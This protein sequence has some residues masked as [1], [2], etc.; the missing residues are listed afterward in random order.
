[1]YLSE[2][3]VLAAYKG[4]KQ[5][6]L[7]E[8]K[9]RQE[10]VSALRHLLASCELM[11]QNNTDTVSL[12]V[13][14]SKARSDFI[15]A[16]SR[17]VS[18]SSEGDYTNDFHL[19]FA[20]R[21]DFGVRSNFFTTRL[22]D[23]R[24]HSLEYPGR[25]K[26]LLHLDNEVVSLTSEINSNLESAYS[27]KKIRAYLALWLLRYTKLGL[28]SENIS[29]KELATEIESRLKEIYHDSI[30]DIF[31][32]T[33]SE[34]N[35]ILVNSAVHLSNEIVNLEIILALKE[36]T[37]EEDKIVEKAHVLKN[38]LGDS[39]EIYVSITK[40]LERGSKGILLSGPPGTSKT[41]Y[42]LKLALKLTEGDL[43]RISR[44][45][46][47]QS[48]SYEDFIEGL[49][50]TGSV[51]GTEPLFKPKFKTFVNFCLKAKN[52]IDNNYYLI[53]DEFTRGDPSRIFGELLTYIEPDYRDIEFILPYSEEKFSVPQNVVILA[54]MNPYDKSVID[55]DAAMERRFEIIELAPSREILTQFLTTNAVSGPTIGNIVNFF[56][57]LNKFAEHGF[58]HTYFK[59]IRTEEDLIM[60]WNHKLKFILEK[61]FKYKEDAFEE[62]RTSFLDTLSGDS[63]GKI[64]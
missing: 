21:G 15:N 52:D 50:A 4:L 45:Q 47:H 27:I 59:D 24:S 25:P 12:Q 22:K 34:L 8:G 57:T 5:M 13:N 1:M 19:E 2:E 33:E 11:K 43:D 49:V 37:P 7:S 3:L 54:T 56:N 61:M 23:S 29:S 55:L 58:G 30:V 38:N 35:N 26:P 28:N 17:V 46:F 10:K 42:A 41:W 53:I 51:G 40:L 20:K 31:I 60:L 44:V 39:D 62:V 63:K 9:S 48:Y 36:E 16:V 18:L 32:P 64:K 6:D 14:D